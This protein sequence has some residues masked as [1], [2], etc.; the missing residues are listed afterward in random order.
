MNRSKKYPVVSILFYITAGILIVYMVWALICC[1]AYISKLIASGQLTAN[2][3]E[4]T[5]ANYYMTNCV[6]YLFYSIIFLFFG[7][8]Y[9]S[10]THICKKNTTEPSDDEVEE[11]STIFESDENENTD[12]FSGWKS[13]Q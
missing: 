12:D 11:P 3:N 8:L 7:R 10:V 5:V 9:S 2:G 6:Q 1:H 13:P 4:F